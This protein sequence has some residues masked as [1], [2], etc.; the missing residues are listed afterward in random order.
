M[1]EAVH[2]KSA[3]GGPDHRAFALVPRVFVPDLGGRRVDG[4]RA[5]R[6]RGDPLP[7]VSRP[8]AVVP[9]LPDSLEGPGRHGGLARAVS[10]LLPLAVGLIAFDGDVVVV[11]FSSSTPFL[12]GVP[13]S[14]PGTR[15]ERRVPLAAIF[16]DAKRL[17]IDDVVVSDL[18]VLVIVS[19][20]SSPGGRVGDLLDDG[21][22]RALLA[23]GAWVQSRGAVGRVVPVLVAAP[24]VAARLPV[25]EGRA[26]QSVPV[27]NVVDEVAL[28]AACT[29]ATSIFPLGTPVGV[30]RARG[31]VD[32]VGGS[33]HG[34]VE[35]W[36]GR[37]IVARG[38][39][40]GEGVDTFTCCGSNTVRKGSRRV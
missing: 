34:W 9:A 14:E 16:V 29:S 4:R 27:V 39:L 5:Q 7:R 20:A 32:R 15:L 35:A 28:S 26:G 2:D 10:R 18:V 40:E 38:H 12:P 22:A 19:S 6:R 17:A 11:V 1:D 25:L 33:S 24:A 31:H 21:R 23:A 3:D 8:A 13:P 37:Q 30:D 36:D